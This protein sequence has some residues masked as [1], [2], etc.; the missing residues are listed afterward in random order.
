MVIGLDMDGVLCDLVTPWLA[1]YNEK[2][3]DSLKLED[4]KRFDLHEFARQDVGKKI[5]QFLRKEIYDTALPI[6]GAVEGVE[7]LLEWGHRV[8]VVTAASSGDFISGKYRWLKYHFPMLTKQDIVIVKDKSLA[9]VGMLVD[10]YEKNLV[11]FH[12]HKILFGQP[13][14]QHVPQF[15]EEFGEVN[16]YHKRVDGWPDLNEHLFRIL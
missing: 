11:N 12:S 3:S 6:P 8:V 13:W 10:D 14:N 1:A 9:H 16:N 2:Y 5:Y 15:E 7:T 4:I